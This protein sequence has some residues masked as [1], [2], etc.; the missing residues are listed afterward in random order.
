MALGTRF[1]LAIALYTVRKGGQGIR[2][3]R[4]GWGVVA[5]PHMTG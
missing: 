5:I 1:R 3:G 2:E 4:G